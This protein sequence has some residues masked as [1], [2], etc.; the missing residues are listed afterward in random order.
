M[1]VTRAAIVN[2]RGKA[3]SSRD[4]GY[5]L[6][7]GFSRIYRG[8]GRDFRAQNCTERKLREKIEIRPKCGGFLRHPHLVCETIISLELF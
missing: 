5:G 7:G 3:S 4:Y 6:D 1:L 2:S 8:G